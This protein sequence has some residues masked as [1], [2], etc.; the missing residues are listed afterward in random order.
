MKIC[1]HS[2]QISGNAK[3]LSLA[4][5]K[6]L[7]YGDIVYIK[8]SFCNHFLR[9]RINGKPKLW[10]TRPDYV[11]VPYKYGLYEYGYITQSD[12]VKVES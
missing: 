7:K 3:E 12:T 9:V 6:S 8:S 4:E 11:E 5:I 10:K 2:N 1:N